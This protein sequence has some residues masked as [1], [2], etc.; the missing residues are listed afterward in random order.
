M[1][2]DNKP[3]M[4]VIGNRVNMG[5]GSTL[6]ALESNNSD[7]R[8]HFSPVQTQPEW[9]SSNELVPRSPAQNETTDIETFARTP[10]RTNDPL[11]RVRSSPSYRPASL[12]LSPR[13][14]IHTDIH[15]SIEQPSRPQTPSPISQT[16]QESPYSLPNTPSER[17]QL[18]DEITDEIKAFSSSQLSPLSKHEQ[19]PWSR[20]PS[21]KT[22]TCNFQARGL[23]QAQRSPTPDPPRSNRRRRTA[24]RPESYQNEFNP[25]GSESSS[26]GS[27]SGH[28]S[29]ADPVAESRPRFRTPNF[30]PGQPVSRSATLVPGLDTF[31]TLPMPRQSSPAQKIPVKSD[32]IREMLSA[33]IVQG[34][35]EPAP[36]LRATKFTKSKQA[37]AAASP[38]TRWPAGP[39]AKRATPEPA[40]VSPRKTRCVKCGRL[41]VGDCLE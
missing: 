14:R 30:S 22:Q 41:H 37:P 27:S 8:P 34:T 32:P 39:K 35:I 20:S 31:P 33:S 10:T 18:R 38:T 23:I 4:T 12:P 21:P 25:S 17:S 3:S 9:V 11:Q 13:P 7:I 19:L 16:R 26:D 6:S 40:F 5:L 29:H 15:P 28:E 24:R 36:Q 1:V 2:M